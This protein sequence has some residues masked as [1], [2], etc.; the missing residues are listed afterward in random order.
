MTHMKRFVIKEITVSDEA[1][2]PI[3]NPDNTSDLF[4]NIFIIIYKS[5]CWKKNIISS[6]IINEVNLIFFLNILIKEEV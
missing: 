5:Q 4:K 3:T 6:L 1:V 2:A